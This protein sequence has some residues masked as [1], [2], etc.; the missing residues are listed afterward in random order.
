MYHLFLYGLIII[1]LAIA[2]I[3]LCLI[4]N[5]LFVLRREMLGNTRQSIILPI[6]NRWISDEGSFFS[7]INQPKYL[8]DS[9]IIA[10]LCEN[11]L[12]S[13]DKQIRYKCQKWLENHEYINKWSKSIESPD[14]LERCNAIEKLAYIRSSGFDDM[15]ISRLE[16][17]NLDV[18]VRAIRALGMS[19]SPKAIKALILKL[20]DANNVHQSTIRDVLVDIGPTVIPFLITEFHDFK[21]Y[22]RLYA[23]DI[24]VWLAS[25]DEIKFLLECLDNKDPEIRSRAAFGLGCVGNAI[26]LPKLID[27][28]RD[29][30]WPVRAKSVSALGKI[31][32]T[33]SIPIL[34][35]CMSDKIWWVRSNAASALMSLGP[36]GKDALIQCLSSKDKFCFDQAYASLQQIGEIKRIVSKTY[37]DAND[38]EN[39][40]RI[41][42]YILNRLDYPLGVEFCNNIESPLLRNACLS[43]LSQF[44]SG[45]IN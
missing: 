37:L 6:F 21:E 44:H 20:K 22:S 35:E 16:D 1:L 14:A 43:K 19:H 25:T 11:Y 27:G 41:V 17:D 2:I 30:E 3:S 5:K 13:Q 40:E 18:R 39:S 45:A 38:M 28:C 31:Q 12:N 8:I 42:A 36:H 24:I 7:E 15:L 10:S 29:P 34:T 9:E 32:L 26:A 23:L 4:A 33:E